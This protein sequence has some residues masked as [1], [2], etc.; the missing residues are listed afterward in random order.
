MAPV[1]PTRA[2][3]FRNKD[4][5]NHRVV[6]SVQRAAAQLR[7]ERGLTPLPTRLSAHVFR[8]TFATLMAEAGAPPK[9][10]KASS[11]TKAPG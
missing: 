3:T 11:V 4:N 2:G 1:F 10:C 7:N 6:A 5:L 9:T 8:R